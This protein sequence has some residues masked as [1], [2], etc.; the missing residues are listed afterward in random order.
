MLDSETTISIRR[1]GTIH[2]NRAAF[3]QFGPIDPDNVHFYRLSGGGGT[4]PLLRRERRELGVCGPGPTAQHAEDDPL[5]F[6]QE[7]IRLVQVK[8]LARKRYRAWLEEKTKTVMI[9]IA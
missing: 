8:P 6:M 7:F 4:R 2:F 9:R 5:E 1:D 3:R